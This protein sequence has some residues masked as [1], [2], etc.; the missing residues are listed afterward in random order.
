MLHWQS[1]QR[2]GDRE[3]QKLLSYYQKGRGQMY[4]WGMLNMQ[5]SKSIVYVYAGE[6]R[7][8]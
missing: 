3:K 7:E 4:L 6:E 8:G 5:K 2:Y 1:Q